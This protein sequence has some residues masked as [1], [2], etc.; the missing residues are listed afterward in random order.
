[1]YLCSLFGPSGRV[2]VFTYHKHD[3]ATFGHAG[4]SVANFLHM[5]VHFM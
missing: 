5:L 1:M 3:R 2:Y 4:S